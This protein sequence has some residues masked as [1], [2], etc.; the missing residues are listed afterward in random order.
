MVSIDKLMELAGLSV[1]A[2]GNAYP[3]S[4]HKRVLCVCGGDLHVVECV[5]ACALGAEFVGLAGLQGL[6]ALSGWHELHP[7]D[8][9]DAIVCG[10]CENA[11]AAARMVT[12]AARRLR[13]QGRLCMLAQL[14]SCPTAHR[15][16]SH[17]PPSAH[18]LEVAVVYA[19]PPSDE[20]GPALVLAVRRERARGGGPL[21]GWSVP[22]ELAREGGEAALSLRL[23]DSPA[24]R[25]ARDV[26]LALADDRPAAA[27]ASASGSSSGPAASEDTP[28]WATLDA[29]GRTMLSVCVETSDGVAQA[30]LP[31]GTALPAAAEALLTTG[32][33][34]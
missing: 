27:C 5:D 2:I 34:D 12:E 4:T 18:S 31:R 23:C 10:T 14:A 3:L 33:A 24:L 25:A 29:T 7:D 32:A 22:V 17:A 21:A 8:T 28:P 26:F 15:F 19:A 6:S 11:E 9:Y 1:A 30:I 13:P 20:E 16:L